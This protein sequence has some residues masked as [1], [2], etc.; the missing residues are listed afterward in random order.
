MAARTPRFTL[1][2]RRVGRRTD[3]V[4][5]GNYHLTRCWESKVEDSWQ[6]C[7]LSSDWAHA[8]PG[9]GHVD[10]RATN[11]RSTVMSHSVIVRSPRHPVSGP[12]RTAS[13]LLRVTYRLP[14]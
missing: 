1:A 8:V 14:G 12:L 11:Q 13:R 6:R 5:Y 10:C 9:R 3:E 4:T 7:A 2:R